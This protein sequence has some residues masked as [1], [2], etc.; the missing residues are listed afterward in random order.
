MLAYYGKDLIPIGYTDSD[1][2][3]DKD[4]HNLHLDQYLL[5]V[6][7]PEFGEELNNLV[8]LIKLWKLSILLLVKQQSKQFYSVSS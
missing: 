8:L 7:E 3:S 5:L 6:V 2:Q 1:F 4:P